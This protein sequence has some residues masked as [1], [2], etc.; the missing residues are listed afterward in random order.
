MAYDIVLAD[1]I[2]A[3]V[4]RQ[5]GFTEKQMFGGICYMING[6]VCTGVINDEMV[7]RQEPERTDELLRNTHVRIF[8]FS[9][10][11]MKGWFFIHSSG[12]ETDKDLSYWAKAAIQYVKTLPSKRSLKTK[13][14]TKHS[15]K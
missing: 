11:P 14:P 7:V 4:Y 2:R 1:R 10:R 12:V 8:D 5:R 6:N 3:K 13:R 15:P 9:G